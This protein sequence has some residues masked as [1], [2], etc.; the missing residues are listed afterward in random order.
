LVSYHLH[1]AVLAKLLI[2][3]CQGNRVW[4]KCLLTD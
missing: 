3:P 1:I 2:P 4:P